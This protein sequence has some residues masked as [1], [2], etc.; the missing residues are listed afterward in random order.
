M[1]ILPNRMIEVRASMIEPKTRMIIL[2]SR[3]I[4]QGGMKTSNRSYI[5]LAKL[6]WPQF[7]LLHQSSW[8]H[9][10]LLGTEFDLLIILV[11]HKR[12]SLL[13]QLMCNHPGFI[14]VILG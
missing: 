1:I 9:P 6:A 14:L 8:V 10:S 7:F 13:H 11:V 2:V 4:K 12:S 5:S 3:M